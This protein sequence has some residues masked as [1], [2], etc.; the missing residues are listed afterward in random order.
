M[1]DNYQFT[2]G[3]LNING[4]NVGNGQFVVDSSGNVTIGGNAK[5]SGSITMAAGSSI[6]WAQVTETNYTQSEAYPEGLTLP[7]HMQAMHMIVPIA[8][9]AEQMQL[10]YMQA[11]LIK[12]EFTARNI[13]NTL[14][15]NG[16]YF[17][18]LF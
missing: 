9:I 1:N 14:T 6:N 7:I 4:L 16:T 12:T 18:V 11:M 15:N 8:L 3:Y 17:G 10:I 2:A 13:F 5:V